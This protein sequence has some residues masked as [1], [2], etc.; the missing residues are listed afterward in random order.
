MHKFRRHYNKYDEYKSRFGKQFADLSKNF[1]EMVP[2]KSKV[3]F[4]WSKDRRVI[5]ESN[6][7]KFQYYGLYQPKKLKKAD[8]IF[9]YYPEKLFYDS[10]NN[11]VYYRD[12]RD[13]YKVKILYTQSP[14]AK[15]LKVLHD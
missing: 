8:Y 13:R 2:L 5:G 15:I 6:W 7:I 11:T 4:P 14:S 3:A 10:K 1:E 9:Y 12:S